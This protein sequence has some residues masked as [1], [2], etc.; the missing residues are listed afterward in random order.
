MFRKTVIGL[1]A[2]AALSMLS[3]TMASARG[4]FGGFHGGCF[5]GAGLAA[6]AIG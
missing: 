2:V 4:G 3:P 5:G 6:G 1:F